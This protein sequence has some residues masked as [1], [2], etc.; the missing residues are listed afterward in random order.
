MKDCFELLDSWVYK[1]DFGEDI[2]LVEKDG[3]E[4]KYKRPVAISTETQSFLRGI[5]NA[6]P[7]QI[8]KELKNYSGV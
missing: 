2:S 7:I 1:N 5:K 8:I 3:I 6:D 4:A